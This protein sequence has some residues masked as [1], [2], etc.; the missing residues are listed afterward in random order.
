MTKNREMFQ[1]MGKT[2]TTNTK[3]YLTSYAQR[4]RLKA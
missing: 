3:Q 2:Q 1:L 4:N